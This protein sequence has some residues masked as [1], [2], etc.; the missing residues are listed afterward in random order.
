MRDAVMCPALVRVAMAAGPDEV[1]T[2]GPSQSTGL[3][4]PEKAS[5]FPGCGPVEHHHLRLPLQ[6]YVAAKLCDSVAKLSRP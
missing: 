3:E 4:R 5:G 1:R 6:R 2:P